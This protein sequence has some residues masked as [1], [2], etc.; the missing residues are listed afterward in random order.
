MDL[1]RQLNIA[2]QASLSR[3][4]ENHEGGLPTANQHKHLRKVTEVVADEPDTT[5]SVFH[6]VAVVAEGSTWL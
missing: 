2:K 1:V 5:P 3:N 4:G 6:Q